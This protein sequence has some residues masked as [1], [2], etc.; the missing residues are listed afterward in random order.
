[1]RGKNVLFSLYIYIYIDTNTQQWTIENCDRFGHF[2]TQVPQSKN[3]ILFSNTDKALMEISN[4]NLL[5]IFLLSCIISESRSEDISSY[6][7]Q[8]R[9]DYRIPAYTSGLN[10]ECVHSKPAKLITNPTQITVCY[11]SLP[12]TY[13]LSSFGDFWSTVLGFGSIKDDFTDMDEGYLFGVWKTGPWLAY[14]GP[15]DKAH[16]W[17]ALGENFLHDP[18]IWRHSC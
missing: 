8:S 9:H 13:Q 5:N 18:Q 12:I 3:I 4:L 17:V 16:E 1:M 11:R 6:F 15:E 2:V 10:I 14:K 7:L